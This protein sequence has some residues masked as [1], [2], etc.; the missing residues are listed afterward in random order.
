MAEY[1]DGRIKRL[2]AALKREGVAPD[3]SEQIMDGG[4]ALTSHSEPDAMAAWFA[5]AM[6]RMDALVEADQ[7]VAVRERCACCLGG[8]RLQLSKAIGQAGGTVEERVAAADAEPFVFGHSVAM[9]PDGRIRVEFQPSDWESFRCSCIRAPGARMSATYCQCCQG[10]VKRHLQFAL[11][12][13]LR[14]WV[15]SSALSSGG[16]SPCSFDFEILD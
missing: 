14:G 2:A 9:Q 13:H 16:K 3:V 10:H 15:R 11:G 1:R 6:D 7:R 4:E 8:K 5:G 12:R